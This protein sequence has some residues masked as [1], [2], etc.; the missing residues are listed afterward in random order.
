MIIDTPW[1]RMPKP[2]FA[3]PRNFDLPTR[4]HLD[5]E[6]ARIWLGT[7]FMPWQRMISDVFGEYDPDT[8][9][10][11]YT[12]IIGTA[13]RRGGKTKWT[14]ARKARKC[15][16]QVNHRSWYTAQTGAHARDAFL[17]FHEEDVQASP[18]GK[19][20]RTLRGR[21]T[22]VMNFPNGSTMRPHPPVE[23]ALDGKEGDDNDIDE[24][25]YFDLEQ[26]KMLMQSISPTQLTRPGAQT[27]IWSA[28]GTAA[29]TWLAQL[30][31]QG[32][33]LC[34]SEDDAAII[35]ACRAAG[36][37]VIEFGIPDDLP[38]D[39]LEAIAHYHPA[40]GHTLN[41]ASLKGLRTDIPDDNEFAR[42]AG[43]RWTEIIGGVID[44]KLWKS[45]QWGDDV[46]EDA[47]IGFGAARSQDGTQ[48]AIVSAVD[49]GDRIIVEVCDVLPTA[50][51]AAEHVEGWAAGDTLAVGKSGPS[52]PLFDD[53]VTRN[54]VEPLGL[55]GRDA[56]AACQ[57]LDDALPHRAIVF[58]PHP[59][60]DA[61]IPIA[62]KRNVDSGGWV[63]AHTGTGQIA[64]LEAATYAVWA[65]KHRKP[66]P[67]PAVFAT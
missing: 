19:V 16:T 30:V 14:T 9:L 18:L 50:W 5:A 60:L 26:G 31:A 23:G 17:K 47:P 10:P 54:N 49:D 61:A 40:F 41:L 39:D 4:G 13:P 34:A 63:W 8:G 22:E 53:L 29:S 55:G 24:A 38:I 56:S 25:W 11:V 66:T 7:E 36:V 37:A 48:V 57:Q 6:F 42:A 15:M 51:R 59:A 45:V 32:R 33:A 58:R 46:P 1:G 43:N 21:G 65:L 3:T 52:A 12:K 20:A 28:G 35:A 67:G 27:F 2:K 62:G 44:A 64:V